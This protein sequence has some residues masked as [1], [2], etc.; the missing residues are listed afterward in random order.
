MTDTTIDI[1]HGAKVI[2]ANMREHYQPQTYR[3]DQRKAAESLVTK[4][5]DLARGL[6]LTVKKL[7]TGGSSVEFGAPGGA[8][9]WIS[10]NDAYPAVGIVDL[11]GRPGGEI[12]W[13]RE[14]EYDP[15]AKAFVG[16]DVDTNIAPT[17]GQ[18]LPRVQPLTVIA[19]CASAVLEASTKK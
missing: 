16:K 12:S 3:A 18:P 8:C 2:L 5:L 11:Y 14:L 7:D 6:G 17:P 13:V 4:F 9:L 19:K 10:E 15:V 1:E